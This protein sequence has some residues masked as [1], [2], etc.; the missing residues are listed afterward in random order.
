MRHNKSGRED[1]D[2]FR[3][4]M[5]MNGYSANTIES[6]LRGVRSYFDWFNGKYDRDPREL[7]REN[8]VDYLQDLKHREV[9]HVTYNSH[10]AALQRLNAFWIERGIQADIVI[11]K[12]DRWKAQAGNESPTQHTTEE[13]E[14]FLQVILESGNRRDYTLA[15]FLAYTGLRVSEAIH[16]QM[17]DVNLPVRQLV[18]QF[19]KG[20]KRRE[21]PMSTRLV[22]VIRDYLRKTRPE[23]R[24]AERSPYLFVSSRGRQISRKTVYSLLV[25]YSR[26]AGVD[27]EITPHSLRHFFCTRALEAGYT[28]EEV[29]QIAGHANVNT[30]LIYAHPSRKS[31]LEKI[32]RL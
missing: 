25:K 17:K 7:F 15:F 6:Y 16:L 20:Q 10:L 1:L 8:I 22:Q 13:V 24:T 31:M 21:V 18:V 5:E 19:G 11:L 23:Y 2:D 12:R 3:R 30:T 32:D 9:G 4:W 29:R 28:I 26:K 27:P 14:R